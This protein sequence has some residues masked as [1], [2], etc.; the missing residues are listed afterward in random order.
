MPKFDITLTIPAE[1]SFN[2]VVE[3]GEQDRAE[4]T[5][6]NEFLGKLTAPRSAGVSF[7]FDAEELSYATEIVK[8][9][10]EED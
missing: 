9:K 10:V 8:K 7:D 6:W 2:A 3:A 5:A 4:Q 1:I